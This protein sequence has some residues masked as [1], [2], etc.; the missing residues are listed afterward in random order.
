M[1][2]ANSSLGNMQQR[3]RTERV[4]NVLQPF[5][6]LLCEAPSLSA[7]VKCNEVL[8]DVLGRLERVFS[9]RKSVPPD[10][11]LHPAL[12]HDMLDNYVNEKLICPFWKLSPRLC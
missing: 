2:E 5:T 12:L 8:W 3:L 11:V 9:R 10:D 7:P 4:L 1:L 6:F